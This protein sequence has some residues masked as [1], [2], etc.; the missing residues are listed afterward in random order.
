MIVRFNQSEEPYQ[1][2]KYQVLYSGC[3]TEE[4]AWEPGGVVHSVRACY[5]SSNEDVS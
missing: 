5:S 4:R 2:N 1:A 3:L